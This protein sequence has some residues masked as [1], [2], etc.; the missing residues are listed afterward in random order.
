MNIPVQEPVIIFGIAI[1]VFL[2]SPLI[3]NKLRIPGIIG[4]IVAGI[5]IGPNG[6]GL[7]AL[8]ETIK[9]LGAVGLLFIIFIA[10]LEL[11]IDGF[12][13]YRHR[14]IL[15]GLLSFF[16]PL[17]FGTAIGLYVEFG[18]AAAILLGSILGSHT[19][20]GY[21]IAS[22]LGIAKNKAV[23]TA[24]GGTLM[25]DTLAML[26]LAVIAGAAS[27]ELSLQFG[28][29][30]ALSTVAFVL[31]IMIGTPK[32]SK[33]FFRNSHN[34]GTLEFNFV[35]TVLFVSGSLALFAGLQPI[36]GAFLA[37]LA[38]NRY[39]YDHGVLMN[40]IRFS[41]NALFI[42]F[43]LLSVGMLMDLKVLMKDPSAWIL[44]LL[45]L[46][47]V[48]IGKALAGW[49]ASKVYNYSKAENRVIFGLSISQAAATLASTLIGFQ[50]ELLDQATVNAVIIMILVTCIIGPYMT[51][52]YGRK[53]ST[54]D[55]AEEEST[56]ESPERILIPVANPDTMESLLDLAFVIRQAKMTEEPL[57]PLSVVRKDVKQAE[58]QVARAEKMLGHAVM[59]CSG[60][61]VPVRLLTRVDE[62]VGRGIER[63]VAEERITTIIAG[64][65]GLKSTE[66]R[67]FG[68]V[69]DNFLDHTNQ[70]TIIAKLG[71]PLN[72]TDRL[73][74]LI[75]QNVH[76]KPGFKD[77]LKIIKQISAQLN[78]PIH[79]LLLRGEKEIFQKVF[80]HIK[81][82]TPTVFTTVESW[83]ELYRDRV[84]ELRKNDLVIVISARKGT[85]AWHPQLEL[86][87]EKMATVI[88]ESFLIFYPTEASEVDIRGARGTEVPR[89]L[90]FK[91][92]YDEM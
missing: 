30:L 54:A 34:E 38:L 41:A 64:W 59:Y 73:V 16:I 88:P 2:V 58:H 69:I 72:T 86:V 47:G 53:L 51:E 56:V 67:L 52:K 22:R 40:R 66:K 8:D 31:F 36:I 10:G 3:M 90:L 14:S 19:L 74:L 60:A 65:N 46:A 91:K 83:E 81:P 84:E 77:S 1:I 25:T 5:I 57:Y 44:T 13:R 32:I 50:L 9:L 63:A 68:G 7:L 55:E 49:I 28:I 71:H 62:N 89:E 12:K 37:G 48:I 15:F 29:T 33:W 21:P 87:P 23:T 42:P 85:I 20:L 27:G 70:R 6:F 92:D 35:M 18:W 75:P 24:I 76:Q 80:N 11:D 82:V 61:E 79:C 39:I 26:F 4:P 78:A 45:I 43:F 17:I